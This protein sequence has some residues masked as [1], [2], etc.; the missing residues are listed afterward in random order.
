MG[1]TVTSLEQALDYKFSDGDILQAALTHRSYEEDGTDY[2]RLEFLGDAVVQLIVTEVLYDR[3]PDMPEG[4]MAKL[5]AAVVSLDVLADQARRLDVG[6]HI[7]LGKGEEL[8]G[9]RNKSSILSDVFEALVGAMFVD[10]GLEP[11]RRLV[12]SSLAEEIS[13]RAS[14]PGRRDYKTRLQEL[15]AKRGEEL[16]Y[17]VSDAG[18][19]HAKVFSATALINGVARGAGTGTSKKAAQQEAARL[20]L[21]WLEDA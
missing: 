17:E 3:F 12:S 15:V 7:R 18:P 8:T 10:G 21:S 13:L 20:V 9:G 4:Q 11:A 19:D 6:P 1:V 14:S 16:T 2:E 5:R